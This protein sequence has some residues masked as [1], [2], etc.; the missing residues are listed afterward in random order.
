MSRR[1]PNQVD[2]AAW[3][4]QPVIGSARDALTAHSTTLACRDAP[5]DLKPAHGAVGLSQDLIG[6]ATLSR[7]EPS[8]PRA[9]IVFPSDGRL[10]RGCAMRRA[11]AV[12]IW[13]LWPS[14]SLCE[15]AI[16]HSH[17]AASTRVLCMF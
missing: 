17:S 13:P 2:F 9:Q 3:D 11:F 7:F 14:R 5:A 10:P 8:R 16:V 6:G 12:L 15:L 4:V 1:L